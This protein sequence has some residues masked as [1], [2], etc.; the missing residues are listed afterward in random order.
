MRKFRLIF[1]KKS[2]S[3]LSQLLRKFPLPPLAFRDRLYSRKEERFV[4]GG[5]RTVLHILS[6]TQRDEYRGNFMRGTGVS[7]KH[8]RVILI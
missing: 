7:S 5:Y 1:C 3:A 4:E 2:R 8:C 6:P